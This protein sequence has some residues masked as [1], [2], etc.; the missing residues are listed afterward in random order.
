MHEGG[1]G[2]TFV[3]VPAGIIK[4]WAMS[5]SVHNLV[6]IHG[7]AFVCM[8]R[9]I[10]KRQKSN[11]FGSIINVPGVSRELS[12]GVVQ[13]GRGSIRTADSGGRHVGRRGRGREG[14]GRQRAQRGRAAKQSSQG[15]EDADGSWATRRCAAARPRRGRV[16]GRRGKQ[17][18]PQ[19]VCVDNYVAADGICA[20][21][22]CATRM[23][24]F[25]ERWGA[26]GVY[27]HTDSWDHTD[28]CRV[29][30]F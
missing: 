11:V 26:R 3:E 28:A 4:L 16:R 23:G 22:E 9:M 7:C 5:P 10:T 1:G 24:G 6:R 19:R 14:P 29:W 21:V 2:S 20:D 30:T 17:Y 8:L 13:A 12:V 15:G 27:A 18:L 25:L